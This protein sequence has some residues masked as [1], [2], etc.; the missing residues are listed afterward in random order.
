MTSPA[1][2]STQS[3][4]PNAYAPPTDDTITPLIAAFVGKRWESH[5]SKAWQKFGSA[6]GLR[7]GTSWNWPA[8][9]LSLYWL[10]YRRQYLYALAYFVGSGVINLVP[11]GFFAWLASIPVLCMYGDRIILDKAYKAADAALR[12]HGPGEKA[13][14]D[15]EAAGGTS[16]LVFLILFI[17]F[18]VVFIGIIA[19]IAIPKFASVKQRAYEVQ[20]RSD[21]RSVATIEDS[22]FATSQK[23]T[24]NLGA[25]VP[26]TG[27]K[28]LQLTLT[29]DSAGYIATVTHSQLTSKTC[30]VARN[31]TKPFDSTAAGGEVACK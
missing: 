27:V 16:W 26:T 25:F 17:P 11:F 5:Y 1:S 21:L 10:L 15:A 31:L 19:A 22:A 20:M 18:I 7:P 24:G 30:A 23:Y 29:S 12:L 3:A 8:G 28:E 13:R 14:A 9:L 4:A 2:G 6:A